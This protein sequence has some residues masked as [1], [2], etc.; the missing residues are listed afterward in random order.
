MI[1]SV[2]GYT[3]EKALVVEKNTVVDAAL[4]PSTGNL[5]VTKKDGTTYSLGVIGDLSS[6][7][8]TTS[9]VSIGAYG[10]G[11]EEVIVPEWNIGTANVKVAGPSSGAP[12]ASVTDVCYLRGGQLLFMTLGVLPYLKG[13]LIT[14]DAMALTPTSFD[15]PSGPVTAIDGSPDGR[16]LALAINTSPYINLY[17]RTLNAA[18]LTKLA[19]PASLPAGQANAVA[20]SPDS[21]FLFVGLNVS[22]YIATYRVDA[23]DTFVK[24]SDPATLPGSVVKSISV[25][26]NGTY[27]AVTTTSAP[28]IILYKIDASGTLTKLAEPLNLPTGTATDSAWSP[29]SRYLA[30]SHSVSPYLTLYYRDKDG[31]TKLENPVDLPPSNGIGVSWSPDGRY[32]SVTYSGSPYFMVYKRSGAKFTKIIDV[33]TPP[34]SAVNT[35]AKWSDDGIYMSLGQTSS[36]YLNVYK[37]AFGQVPDAISRVQIQP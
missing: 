22:P 27:L 2:T 12:T 19:N 23:S 5:T 31:F 26:S 36:P 15:D 7:Q 11:Y 21:R 8:V 17:K 10:E 16:Y 9:L 18:S 1:S 35:A 25:S 4:D 34:V 32:L 3:A 6:R 28:Y 29:D 13:F 37:T 33:S 24:L 20:W 30:I 14:N